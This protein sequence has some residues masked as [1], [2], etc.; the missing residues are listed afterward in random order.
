MWTWIYGTARVSPQLTRH[1]WTPYLGA[2]QLEPWFEKKT[3]EG[4]LVRLATTWSLFGDQAGITENN[5]YINQFYMA[6]QWSWL[7]EKGFLCPGSGIILRVC[8]WFYQKSTLPPHVINLR[9]L[10][11]GSKPWIK[12][13]SNNQNRRRENLLLEKILQDVKLSYLVHHAW[14]TYKNELP[15][16]FPKYYCIKTHTDMMFIFY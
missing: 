9:L 6:D 13:C 2:A 5:S 11:L 12:L 7:L 8:R 4:H 10:S 15:L 1:Y 3:G 16:E 14:G